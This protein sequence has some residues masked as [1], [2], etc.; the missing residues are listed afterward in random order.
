MA[1]DIKLSTDKQDCKF[2]TA[3][4]GLKKFTNFTYHHKFLQ[5]A[6]KLTTFIH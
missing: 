2:F 4:A 3:I 6:T 5:F 1:N